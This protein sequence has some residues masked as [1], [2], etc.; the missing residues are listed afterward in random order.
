MTG[1]VL[2]DMSGKKIAPE[3]GVLL[4]GNVFLRERTDLRSWDP[5]QMKIN[6]ALMKKV[7]EK[8]DWQGAH[9]EHVDRLAG[10]LDEL[11]QIISNKDTTRIDAAHTH[12]EYALN[13]LRDLVFGL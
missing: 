6:V 3:N 4:L 9:M 13:E 10:S 5:R 7:V 1:E 11:A 8:T 12:A 2:Q